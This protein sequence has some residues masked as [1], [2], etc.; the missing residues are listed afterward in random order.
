L[1]AILAVWIAFTSPVVYDSVILTFK[2]P[3][4]PPSPSLTGLYVAA[5]VLIV[6]VTA[7]IGA[8]LAARISG[9]MEAYDAIK[10][11]AR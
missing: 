5:S 4:V 8:L 6:M 11:G 2:M 7:G 1:T 9:R 10:K 3:Y